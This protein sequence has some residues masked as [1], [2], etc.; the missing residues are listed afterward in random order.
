MK[1]NLTKSMLKAIADY[2]VDGEPLNIKGAA[3]IVSEIEKRKPFEIIDTEQPDFLARVQPSGYISYYVRY[4]FGGKK[5]NL[6]IGNI[7]EVT[8]T[9]ARAKAKEILSNA[10]L[11]VDPQQQK[12][13]RVAA[14][15]AEAKAKTEAEKP[16][17]TL[18][19]FINND[20]E[21]NRTALNKKN[22]METIKRLK[23]AFKN[24]L[25]KPLDEINA[26]DITLWWTDRL[27]AG[28]AKSTVNRDIIAL[29][30]MFTTAEKLNKVPI[31][32][33]RGYSQL[34]EDGQAP[35]RYLSDAEEASLFIALD[36][37][38]AELVAGRNRGNTWRENRGY[39][40]YGEIADPLKPMIVVSLNTGI[41]W[42][43]LVG[44]R[45]VNIDF[46]KSQMV[47][48]SGIM[49]NKKL[50]YI[51]LNIKVLDELNKWKT[52]TGGDKDPSRLIFPGRAPNQKKDKAKRAWASLKKRAK[53]KNFRWHDLRH[54]FAS[55][56][57]MRGVDL[58]TVRELMGHSKIEQTLR[59]A[60]LAPEHKAA[61]VAVL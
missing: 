15:E 14:A 41:R 52:A 44:L 32:P 60:H 45:W 10:V 33:L 43:T 40:L 48:E 38:E 57:V 36:E 37:R 27:N 55:K 2:I 6:P 35:V 21:P 61:A 30:S 12:K 24:L 54:T 46:D 42:G 4:R 5:N 22:G 50:L 49:K 25:N 13:D 51:P 11:G 3:E 8:T 47:V 39:P 53:I 34:K 58:N 16:K 23:S 7:K 29:K 31:H 28:L 19:D 26:A 56:L 59:Y 18:S 1:R 17:Y 20:Y 9:Q